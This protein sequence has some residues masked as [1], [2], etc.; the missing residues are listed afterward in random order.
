MASFCARPKPCAPG[1][2]PGLRASLFSSFSPSD[3]CWSFLAGG[4]GLAESS[5]SVGLSVSSSAWSLEGSRD[6]LSQGASLL[7]GRELLREF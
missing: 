4:R 3:C 7:G 2:F 5:V 6:A 1:C